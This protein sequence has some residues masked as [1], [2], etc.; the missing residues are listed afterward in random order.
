MILHSL[1]RRIPAG[2]RNP[3]V[4]S[5][6]LPKGPGKVEKPVIRRFR[7]DDTAGS[8]A[9]HAVTTDHPGCEPVNRRMVPPAAA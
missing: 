7:A 1:S 2:R 5:P 8:L 3:G 6:A 4:P 9:C